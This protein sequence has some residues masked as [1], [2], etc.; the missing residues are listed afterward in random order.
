MKKK[1]DKNTRWI[2]TIT[3]LSF[4]IS[5]ILSLISQLVIPNTFLLVN[6]L[7]VLLF[8]F[9][10]II[11]DIIGLAVTTADPKSFHS[12]ATQK[13][14]GSKQAIKLINNKTKVSSFC[15]DV[16]GD[17]CGV[18]SGSCGLTISLKISEIFN[19]NNIIVTLLVTSIISALTIGGKAVGK[20]V[21]V[22]KSNEIVYR[23][24]KFLT[25]FSKK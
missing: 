4:V 10:G 9:L 20:K 1:T 24:T 3:V 2:T 5:L 16:I 15:N 8:I 7:L 12:M 14:K 11:F 22:N 18:I 6:I 17:I 25:L 13:V 23:V 21:A 19:F